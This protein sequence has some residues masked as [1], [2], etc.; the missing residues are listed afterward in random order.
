MERI[1]AKD[2]ADLVVVVNS[3]ENCKEEN[4]KNLKS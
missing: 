4:E 1:Y 3:F 2:L